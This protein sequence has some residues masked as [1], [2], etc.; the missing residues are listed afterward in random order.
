MN[1]NKIRRHSQGVIVAV[2]AAVVVPIAAAAER[3][4]ASTQ[5]PPVVVAQAGPAA[6]RPGG[7]VAVP[8]AFRPV[9]RGVREAAAEGNEALRRYIWRTRMIYNYY[10]NDFASND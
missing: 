6:L 5:P 4:T 9:E 1:Q 7:P 2:L 3:E 8:Q 10:Y